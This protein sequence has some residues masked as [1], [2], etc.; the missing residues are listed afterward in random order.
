MQQRQGIKPLKSLI[1]H[2]TPEAQAYWAE[3]RASR[4]A[5]PLPDFDEPECPECRGYGYVRASLPVGHPKFGQLFPCPRGQECSTL[6][7]LTAERYSKLCTVAQIPLEYQADDMTLDGWAHLEQFPDWI[8]GKRG[9]YGAALAFVAARERGFKFTLEEAAELGG[10]DA[11]NFGDSAKC[12]MVYSGRNGVG[13]TSL[14]VATARHLLDNGVAVMYLRF[15]EFFDGLKERFK[16]KTS[17]EYGGDDADDEAEY[18]RQYQQAPVLVL[19]EFYAEATPWRRDM[20]EA[21]INYRYTHQLPTIATT[22][23]S[24][25]ELEQAWGL[26]T[27][28]RFEAMAHWIE[29]GG[30]ELRLRGK[31]WTSR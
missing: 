18:M 19:D 13:K 21:L 3:L 20:A 16:P 29:V 28:H 26:T 24:A 4:R 14:A 7:A 23:Y 22:N 5:D 12:S 10:I 2:A 9:A 30:K 8:E 11:P 25:A 15:A 31:L 17:Y 1:V 6:R 27:M